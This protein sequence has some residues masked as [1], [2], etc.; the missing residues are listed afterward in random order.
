MLPRTSTMSLKLMATLP[1]LSS[2]TSIKLTAAHLHPRFNQVTIL[3]S[4]RLIQTDTQSMLDPKFKAFAEPKEEDP[5]D[6]VFK[7]E[8]DK[9]KAVAEAL[10]HN[11]KVQRLREVAIKPYSGYQLDQVVVEERKLLRVAKYLAPQ[12]KEHHVKYVPPTN[13]QYV[14]FLT[15]EHVGE[16][17][18]RDRRPS[19]IIDLNRL[20]KLELFTKAQTHKLLLICHRQWIQHSNLLRFSCSKYPEFAQNKLYLAKLW[21]RIVAEVKNSKDMF[22]D[23]PLT[24]VKRKSKRT[25]LAERNLTFPKEWLAKK[26]K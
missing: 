19:M 18:D 21:K 8:A 15:I 5:F 17:V 16:K 20:A 10:E 1:H 2:L 23:I 13:Q 9:R 4:K 24:A 22:A 7:S 3:L 14:K 6:W 11:R 12:L 26:T 25:I